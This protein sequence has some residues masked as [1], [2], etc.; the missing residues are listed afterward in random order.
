MLWDPSL[1]PCL[2][3]LEAFALPD[4]DGAVVGIRDRSGLSDVV[5]ALSEA[6]LQV[7]ALMDG[8]NTCEDIR[9]T[10]SA[11]FGCSLSVDTLQLMLEQLDRA[12]LLDGPGFES[13]YQ[14]RLDE[15]RSAGTRDMP[16][17]AALVS[18]RAG[19]G[20]PVV[21]GFR[22]SISASRIRLYVMATLR[23][24]TMHNTT[25]PSCPQ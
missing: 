9:R 21:R 3:P 25:S 7:M 13:Y 5:L 11:S 16:H 8:A 15:Y 18:L 22:A 17:A 1:K 6:A 24:A 10:F 4:A 23:A 20:R 12:H 14:S 19:S 2:R